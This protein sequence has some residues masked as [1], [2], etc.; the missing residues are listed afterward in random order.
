MKHKKKSLPANSMKPETLLNG[1]HVSKFH[2]TWNKIMFRKMQM[3]PRRT[4][5]ID[6]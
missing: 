5:K 4:K 2:A 1:S 3:S 6:E